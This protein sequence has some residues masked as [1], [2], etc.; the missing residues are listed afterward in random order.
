M[1]IKVCGLRDQENIEQIAAMQFDYMGFIFYPNSKRFVGEDFIMPTISD[2]IKKVGVFVNA[3]VEYVLEK[4]KKYILKAIQ[5]HGDET[6]EY[7]TTLKKQLPYDIEIIKAFGVDETFDF[8][9]LKPYESICN[10]FLFDTK[11]KDYGGSGHQ[12][13]WD[14][15]KKYDNTLPYFLSGGI[16]IEDINKIKNSTLKLFAIDV[17]SKF[18]LKP[19]LK[20]IELLKQL[21]TN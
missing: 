18:E 10:Y 15:L 9:Q 4:T 5:L 20:N 14:I 16:G 21:K 7:C 3:E 1:K 8:I 19:G 6:A 17:N 2:S 11:T 12:F 13:S